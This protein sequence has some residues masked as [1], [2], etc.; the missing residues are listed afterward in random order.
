MPTKRIM[1]V[2]HG[3]KPNPDGSIQG[4]T[5]EGFADPDEL[6]VRGWQRAGVA[7]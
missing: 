3:E 6:S 7:A 2:R 5:E 1:V 4:V